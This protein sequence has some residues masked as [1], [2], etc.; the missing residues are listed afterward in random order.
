MANERPSLSVV[1]EKNKTLF[2]IT[3]KDSTVSFN[4]NHSPSLR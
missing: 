1:Y 3:K 4:L 2:I